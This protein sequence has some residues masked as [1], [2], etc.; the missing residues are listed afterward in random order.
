MARASRDLPRI[1]L[2][3][4]PRPLRDAH[5]IGGGRFASLGDLPDPPQRLHVAG[6]LPERLVG[7]VGTRRSDPEADQFAEH[8]ARELGQ[9]GIGTVSGGARGIDAAVHRGSLQASAPTVAVLA[10]HPAWAY[11]SAHAPL[12][13]EIVRAGGALLGEHEDGRPYPSRFLQR[14]RLIAALAEAVVVVQ[15]PPRSGALSTARV[16]QALG[17]PL[18]VVPASPWDPRA[19]GNRWLIDRGVR[20]CTGLWSLREVLGLAD[21]PLVQAAGPAKPAVGE[22]ALAVWRA[23][24][25]RPRHADE[26]AAMLGTEVAG[27]HRALMELVVA[28]AARAVDGGRYVRAPAR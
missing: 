25:T 4:P 23:L 7:V 24:G 18:F 5:L 2:D 28:G 21:E 13:A 16:A 22:G 1:A 12:F 6:T 3:P 10:T 20:P 11:P 19:G 26:V 27:V 15:A 9:A 8:L 17:R 14:N